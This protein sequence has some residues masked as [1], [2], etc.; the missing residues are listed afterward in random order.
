[1]QLEIGDIVLYQPINSPDDNPYSPAENKNGVT[2]LPAMI[3]RIW[4]ADEVNL[5][6]F[7][8]YQGA[9]WKQHV[10]LGIE[11]GTWRPKNKKTN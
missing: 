8:D 10:K 6:V 2:V 3:V 7:L 5:R 1:M 9:I 4:S 11:P